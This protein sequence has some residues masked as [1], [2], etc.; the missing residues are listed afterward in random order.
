MNVRWTTS[1]LL[2]VLSLWLMGCASTDP[3]NESARPWNSPRG[4]ETGL[5]SQMFEG[6]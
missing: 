4:W 2:A 1:L 5:P 3:A 6:R